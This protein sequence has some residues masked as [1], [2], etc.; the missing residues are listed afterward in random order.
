MNLRDLFLRLTILVV[1]RMI[2]IMRMI[3]CRLG[4]RSIR[5]ITLCFCADSITLSLQSCIALGLLAYEVHYLTTL[6]E[7]T[8]EAHVVRTVLCTAV[9][10]RRERRRREAVVTATLTRLGAVVPHSDNH[11]A[12][13]I[14]DESR[15]GNAAV[16]IKREGLAEPYSSAPSRVSLLFVRRRQWAEPT[17]P[18]YLRFTRTV[19]ETRIR[20]DNLVEAYPNAVGTRTALPVRERSPYFSFVCLKFLR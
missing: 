17:T 20:T 6:V 5:S 15:Y 14:A 1:V 3:V 10:A 18:S 4:S 16:D 2:V 8:G 13:T 19:L 9:G 7:A 12:E 11:S